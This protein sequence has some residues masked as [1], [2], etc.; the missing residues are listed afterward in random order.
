MLFV[1]RFGIIL[2]VASFWAIQTIEDS[3]IESGAVIKVVFPAAFKVETYF[4]LRTSISGLSGQCSDI[5]ILHVVY[6]EFSVLTLFLNTF[7][8]MSK[9]I[10]K[11]K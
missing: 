7:L 6:F 1:Q 3:L 10:L 5:R 2:F 4:G 11:A 9:M 8:K